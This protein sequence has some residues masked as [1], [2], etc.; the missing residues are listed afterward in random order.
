MS[1]QNFIRRKT[2]INNSLE[3]TDGNYILSRKRENFFREN[4]N[5][6]KNL[7]SLSRNPYVP[8]DFYN[9][10]V[11][12]NAYQVHYKDETQKNFFPNLKKEEIS[13]NKAKINANL[14]NRSLPR[15]ENQL[16]SSNINQYENLRNNRNYSIPKLIKTYD[17]KRYN[18]FYGNKSN[19]FKNIKNIRFYTPEP[20]RVTK[21]GKI[22]YR[23]KRTFNNDIFNESNNYNN[24]LRYRDSNYDDQFERIKFNSTD[25]KF[26]PR[27]DRKFHKSQIFNLYK[28]FLVDEFQEYRKIEY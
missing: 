17:Q 14:K 7:C 3:R 5:Y 10:Q 20:L 26:F 27:I 6:T 23:L 13:D 2:P 19:I 8:F 16:I 9:S 24:N 18:N 22:I 11:D 12:K 25:S 15:T 4:P 28:P 21:N 1:Y